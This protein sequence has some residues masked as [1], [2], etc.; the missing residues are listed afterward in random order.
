MKQQPPEQK[1]KKAVFPFLKKKK[2]LGTKTP[3][4]NENSAHP[5]EK[6]GSEK[7]S[8][9]TIFIERNDVDHLLTLQCGPL[10]DP[11]TPPNVD[12]LLTL[13]HI[14]VC[15]YIYTRWC[16]HFQGVVL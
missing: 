14:C 13:Q 11:K 7:S 8:E 1:M 12:H 9:T 2:L 10:I 4:N 5:S 6:L 16:V 3:E 15:I